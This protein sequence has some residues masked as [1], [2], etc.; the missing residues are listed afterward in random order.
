MSNSPLF[1]GGD[2]LF[3]QMLGDLLKL[4]PGAGSQQWLLAEQMATEIAGG[5]GDSN[6][7]PLARIELEQLSAI[8]ALHVNEIGGLP[9]PPGGAPRL[10]P[11]SRREWARRTLSTWRPVLD[12]LSEALGPDAPPGGPTSRPGAGPGG[13]TSRPDAGPGV[14]PGVGPGAGTTG[15]ETSGSPPRPGSPPS[16]FPPDFDLSG[17]D[18]SDLDLS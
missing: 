5:E 15:A 14:G 3:R 7:D 8:A 10:V 18:L 2:E 13:P 1:G 9:P 4:M 17:L 16:P 6:P 11:V 12:R